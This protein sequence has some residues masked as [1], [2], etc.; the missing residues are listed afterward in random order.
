MLKTV[1]ALIVACLPLATWALPDVRDTRL[2][3]SPTLSA[4]HL[5][6]VCGGDI[7]IAERSDEAVLLITRRGPSQ[8]A[9]PA[10]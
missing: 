5:A 8:S 6:F 3:R 10:S 2:L 4:Q 9:S 1:A 7:W